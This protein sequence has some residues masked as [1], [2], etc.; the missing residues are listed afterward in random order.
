VDVLEVMCAGAADDEISGC[1]SLGND[2]IGHARV[3]PYVAI[4]R[5]GL[6]HHRSAGPYPRQPAQAVAGLVATRALICSRR[7][8]AMAIVIARSTIGINGLPPAMNRC[9]RTAP[10]ITIASSNAANGASAGTKS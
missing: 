7:R 3:R 8:Y 6:N 9:V 1:T 2:G 10:I 4:S 5:R